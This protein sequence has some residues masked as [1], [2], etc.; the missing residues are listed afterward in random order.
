MIKQEQMA[1]RPEELGIDAASLEKL[2]ARARREVD[3]GTLPGCQIAIARHGKVAALRTFGL[4]RHGGVDQP[5]SDQTLYGIFS[6]TKAFVAAAVWKLI[7]DGQLRIEERVAEIIPE[8][9]SNG[10]GGLTVEQVMLHI[11][12]FPYAPFQPDHWEDR[13]KRLEQFSKWRLTWEPNSRFE[14]HPTAA[15]WVLAEIIE[16][17]SGGDFRQFIRREILDPLE[18]SEMFIGLPEDKQG[19]VADVFYV[20]EPVPPPGGWAQVTPEA[21]LGLNHPTV[22]K[23]G[24]P[25]GG[26]VTGAGELALFYQALVHGGQASNGKR[27]LKAE[28]IAYATKVRT[29]DHHRDAL[30]NVPINRGLSI[31][32]AGGDGFSHYRGF[33]KGTSPLAF[34]HGGAG[35]QIAWGDPESGISLGFC[36]NGFSDFVSQGR[37]IT[38]LSSLAAQCAA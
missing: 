30:W 31:C 29:L 14:Y 28:T 20:S 36:T 16:R 21:I 6:C 37:R 25:G 34:G 26:G 12:G 3:D 10:K 23:I 15:H 27:I 1:A 24:I 38:A 35:G 7:E 2:L 11:G 8:F 17:R 4:A 18:L 19:R 9:G 32:V 5:A 13:E 22:R 33:G